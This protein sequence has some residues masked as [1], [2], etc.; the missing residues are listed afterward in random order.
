MSSRLIPAQTY[1]IPVHPSTEGYDVLR[2]AVEKHTYPAPRPLPANLRIAFLWTHGTGFHKEMM[3]PIMRQ[4]AAQLR[5]T[6]KYNKVEFD[7]I[8]WDQRNHGDSARLNHGLLGMNTSWYDFGM[9]TIH[10]IDTLKLKRDYD[11]VIGIGH[12]VGA[13]CMILAQFAQPGIFDGLCSIEP[14]VRG[15]VL[16]FEHRSKLPPLVVTNACMESLRNRPFWKSLHPEVLENY[17]HYGLYTTD[18]GSVMLKCT[19]E[20]E[21]LTYWGDAYDSYTAFMSLKNLSVPLHVVLS[22]EDNW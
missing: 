10:I 1:E 4:F 6:P 20:Q 19:K 21:N 2:I 9:D 8:S 15:R 3:H 13:T 11:K 12:S 14:L 7:F 22:D 18:D 16:D 5:A 17:V